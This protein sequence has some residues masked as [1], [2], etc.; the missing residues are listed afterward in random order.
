MELIDKN[1]DLKLD[2]E[3]LTL[4]LGN[5]MEELVAN[6]IIAFQEMVPS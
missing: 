4:Y 6:L 1:R 5:D 2:V 3:E